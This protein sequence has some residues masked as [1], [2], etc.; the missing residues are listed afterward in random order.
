MSNQ[1]FADWANAKTWGT[2]NYFEAGRYKLALLETYIN[3]GHKGLRGIAEFV[4]LESTKTEKD[5]EPAPVGSRRSAVFVLDGT[6]ADTGK[7]KLKELVLGLLPPGNAAITD[8]SKLSA[9]Y[10]EIY[11]DAKRVKNEKSGPEKQV[12][13]GRFIALDAST[14][15]KPTKSTANT[16]NPVFITQMRWGYVPQ[17]KEEYEAE[18]ARLTAAGL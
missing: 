6:N 18:R 3:N 2:G 1:E 5:K 14:A 4:V 17:T 11:S 13:R 9:F 7:G 12:A 15:S 8:S 16:A 10:G